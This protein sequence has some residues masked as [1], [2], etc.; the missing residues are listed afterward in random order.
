MLK[1]TIAVNDDELHEVEA[2]YQ[3]GPLDGICDYLVVIDH[4][5]VGRLSHFRPDGAF[6]LAR[7][8]LNSFPAPEKTLQ[9]RGGLAAEMLAQE[10][11][12]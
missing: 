9:E 12:S 3:R 2:H 4:E 1:I 5:P 7:K 8:I 11:E 10:G 6:A